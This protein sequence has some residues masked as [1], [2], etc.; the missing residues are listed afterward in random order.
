[1]ADDSRKHIVIITSEPEY[2]TEVSLTQFARE[3]LGKDFRVSLVYGDI[4][5][6]SIFPNL[7][8]LKSAD[9]ALISVRRQTLLPEQLQ[10][11]RD[12]VSAGKPV[13]GIRTASHAFCLRGKPAPD[14][15][16]DWAEFDR[17]V[18][19]GNY[20]GHHGVGSETMITLATNAAEH[21]IMA[22]VDATEL[23]GKGSLYKVSP[24]QLTATPLLIGTIPN[25]TAEP[26]AW[27]NKRADGGM[28]FYTS[29]GHVGDF[30]QPAFRR[31]LK[32]ACVWIVKQP[33]P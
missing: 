12:F 33:A 26:V 8:V 11:I 5:D 21:P 3:E 1:V 28:S 13:I 14:G 15:R 10:L 9:L 31:L 27:V 20:T 18:I 24:L 16:A 22:G 19:G 17:D 6:G 7:E 32:N 25:T 29:L 23:Q 2:R 30:E 4:Q